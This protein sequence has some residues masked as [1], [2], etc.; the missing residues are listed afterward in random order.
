MPYFPV[1]APLS[2]TLARVTGAG[3]RVVEPAA[4]RGDNGTF[5]L[6]DASDGV[7][8]DGPAHR[9]LVLA[10]EPDERGGEFGG[11]AC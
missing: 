8:A 7:C 6:L 3:G 5:S 2:Q 1:E 11:H 4:A 10:G 9:R